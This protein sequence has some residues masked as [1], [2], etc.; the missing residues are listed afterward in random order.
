MDNRRNLY[1]ILQVQPDASLEVIRNNY[2]TLLQKLR[3]HPDLG[4]DS[5]N[6]SQI[7]QAYHTLRDPQKRADYDRQLLQEYH[8]QVLSQGHLAGNVSTPP[9]QAESSN[10]EG[11]NRRN[12]YRILQI[13]T[14]APAAIIA[15]N[16]QIQMKNPQAPIE[17]IQEA[18]KVLSDPHK[19]D[20]YDQLLSGRSNT[21][22]ADPEPANGYPLPDE[23]KLVVDPVIPNPQTTLYQPLITRFC[24]FCKTPHA[25][26]AMD[27]RNELCIDCGSPLLAAPQEPGFRSR[28]ELSRM[29]L[30]EDLRYYQDWPGPE[31]R[32]ILIDLSP[33]GLR[34]TTTQRLYPEQV[35]KVE[36]RHFKSVARIMHRQPDGAGESVGSRFITIL[37]NHQQGNFVSAQA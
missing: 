13:Q 23:E 34:F 15:A 1:R 16:Y 27:N 25:L 37:F 9:R 33:D 35:I 21:Q 14:D 29:A 18:F 32:G 3:I 8:I 11:S 10:A 6:A 12:Y 20:A 31:Y 2:R 7:N 24:H 28:R 22:S 17:L 26:S 19:R 30:H 5:W 4:G 36:C